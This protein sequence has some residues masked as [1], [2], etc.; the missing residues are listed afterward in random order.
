MKN[1]KT[2]R[3]KRN[4]TQKTLSEQLGV[5]RSTIAK[6]ETGVG[7]PTTD[8]LKK[9]ADILNCSTDKILGR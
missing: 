6:W 1:L 7:Y 4:L 8:N 9:L 5:E 2:L 3:E